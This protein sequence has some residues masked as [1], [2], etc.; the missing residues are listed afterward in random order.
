[1]CSWAYSDIGPDGVT[2]NNNINAD[3][4]FANASQGDFHIGAS[5]PCRDAADP[6]ATLDSDIDRDTRP[7]G[8]ARDIGADE[9][10]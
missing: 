2:G 9:A 7:Q 6:G 5:S 1:M 4:L 8:A 10:K 3:P